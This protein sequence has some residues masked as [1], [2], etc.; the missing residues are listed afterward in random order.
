MPTTRRAPTTTRR[1]GRGSPPD[2][3]SRDPRGRRD[4]RGRRDER[5]P[6]RG[7]SR[8]DIRGGGRGDSSYRSPRGGDRGRGG[9]RRGRSQGS[10]KNTAGLI[11]FICGLVSTACFFGLFLAAGFI[12]STGDAA[13]GLAMMM[14]LIAFYWIS[15]LIGVGTGIAGVVARNAPKGLAITGLIINGL[16]MGLGVLSMLMNLSR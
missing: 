11:S 15:M 2:R 12:F 4:G 14:A 3:Q 9:G 7:G 1:Q 8:R 13:G 10:A 6:R 5:E 16:W